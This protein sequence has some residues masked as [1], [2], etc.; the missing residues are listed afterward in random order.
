MQVNILNGLQA[1]LLTLFFFVTGYIAHSVAVRF[2]PRRN[3][4]IE[5]L[6]LRFLAYGTTN[7]LISFPLILWQTR[8]SPKATWT[9]FVAD[10]IGTYYLLAFAVLFL[11]PIVVG[12]VVGIT[13][14]SY[15]L[16]EW[17]RG[18]ATWDEKIMRT[19]DQWALIT[20]EGGSKV[21]GLLD[22]ESSV[23]T[24]STDKDLLLGQVYKM[25]DNKKWQKV[26]RTRGMLIRGST[27]Q[28]I[29][30][31]SGRPELEPDVKGFL[32]RFKAQHAASRRECTP[33]SLDS[34]V[35]RLDATSSM[36]NIDEQ[37]ETGTDKTDF[38]LNKNAMY[39]L[40]RTNPGEVIHGVSNWV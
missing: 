15:S 30:F 23:F 12:I 29:E 39:C 16:H 26:P 20:L 25:D 36:E 5:L 31:W 19:R 32:A 33:P 22:H 6:F 34:S 37:K 24:E 28:S 10:N 3:E 40:A 27:I 7:A 14:W 9:S 2:S 35:I 13:N 18:Y 1:F 17:Y 11:V 38:A 4:R 21:L 8:F